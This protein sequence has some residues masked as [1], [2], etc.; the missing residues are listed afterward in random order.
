RHLSESHKIHFYL[1][2]ASLVFGRPM[3]LQV[4]F[5]S[6][7]PVRLIPVQYCSLSAVSISYL[8]QFALW[9]LAHSFEFY[10]IQLIYSLISLIET[11][12]AAFLFLRLTSKLMPL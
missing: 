6:P 9:K 11:S 4:Y 1:P 12:N 10:L 3:I 7:N 2:T 5:P 8:S